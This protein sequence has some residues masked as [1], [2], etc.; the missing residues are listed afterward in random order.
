[1]THISVPTASVAPLNFLRYR[2]VLTPGSPL[3]TFADYSFWLE[4]GMRPKDF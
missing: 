4:S 3:W 2:T 1:V